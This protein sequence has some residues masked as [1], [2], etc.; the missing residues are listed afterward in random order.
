[1]S[2]PPSTLLGLQA[3]FKFSVISTQT[4]NGSDFDAVVTVLR[5]H[6]GPYPVMVHLLDGLTRPESM[7]TTTS[8]VI[9][10]ERFQQGK[11]TAGT[12]IPLSLSV[13]DA[14]YGTPWC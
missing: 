9:V 14:R 12:P 1:M 8:R 7:G 11:L 6:A 5:G 3:T 13:H 4:F 2:S 10:H